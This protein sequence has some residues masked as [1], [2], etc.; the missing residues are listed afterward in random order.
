V[1]LSKSLQRSQSDIA[2]LTQ[3]LATLKDAKQNL[4]GEL[5]GVEADYK[6]VDR[7]RADQARQVNI[8]T[9]ELEL[10]QAE[11]QR[12]VKMLENKGVQEAELIARNKGLREQVKVASKSVDERTRRLEQLS[13]Q[14]RQL[15]QQ[16]NY[17]RNAKADTTVTEQV[18]RDEL[19]QQVMITEDLIVENERAKL[20]RRELQA[21]L[22]QLSRKLEF[23]QAASEG[24]QGRSTFSIQQPVFNKPAP[25]RTMVERQPPVT[26]YAVTDPAAELRRPYAAVRLKDW[27]KRQNPN[28]YSLQ[29]ITL[30]DERF[31][32]K[33]FEMYPLNYGERAFYVSDKDG[34][35]VYNVIFGVFDSELAAQQ[36]MQRLPEDIKKK[37]PLILEF[38]SIQK[39]SR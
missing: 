23:A 32:S 26:T 36:G 3:T 31:V 13:R 2:G 25:Q 4:Q 21:A 16:V 15:E 33:F 18:L 22:E 6:S 19:S 24:L 1:R 27:I 38:A 11:N 8:I 12:L 5:R 7:A 37:H 20:K 10:A 14:K 35:Q 9:H 28:S 30:P 17:G 39:L 29:L 34:K